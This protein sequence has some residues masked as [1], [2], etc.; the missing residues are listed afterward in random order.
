MSDCIFCKIARGEI[1]AHKVYEDEHTLAFFDITPTAAYHTLV[2]SK[3]HYT[4]ML[5]IPADEAA[6]I[7]RAAKRVVD[8]YKNKLGMT[9][10]NIINNSGTAAN[11]EVPHIHF[12]IIP[13]AAGDWKDSPW[14]RHPELRE[15][16][17]EMLARVK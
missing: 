2:I 6:H 1:P 12:H 11:Q 4:N 16:F 14:Q 7:M 5:D 9:D 15:K 13:R 17:D 8:L 10:V 3:K